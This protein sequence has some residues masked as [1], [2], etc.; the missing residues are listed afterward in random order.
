MVKHIKSFI[1]LLIEGRHFNLKEKVIINIINNLLT[2]VILYTCLAGNGRKVTS[3]LPGSVFRTVSQVRDS[4]YEAQIYVHWD[5]FQISIS[6]LNH[7]F[8]E[9]IFLVL[10]AIEEGGRAT[11]QNVKVNKL[12]HRSIKKKLQ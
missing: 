11:A 10:S 7:I 4:L 3:V 6:S 2:E 9:L 12:F 5:T 1:L 8:P